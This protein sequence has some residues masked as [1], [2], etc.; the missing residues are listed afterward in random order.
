MNI[1]HLEELKRFGIVEETDY[2][3]NYKGIQ[4]SSSPIDYDSNFRTVH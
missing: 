2:G 3:Y 4:E 1:Q